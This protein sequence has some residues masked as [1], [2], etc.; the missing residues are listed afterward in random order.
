MTSS[1]DK[2]VAGR[3]YIPASRP[4]GLAHDRR[5]WLKAAEGLACVGA[6]KHF[7]IIRF[8]QDSAPAVLL[9]YHSE[10]FDTPL[11]ES[12]QG[13]LVDLG[14]GRTERRPRERKQ[15]RFIRQMGGC[16]RP[17]VEQAISR[18]CATLPCRSGRVRRR[19]ALQVVSG[20]P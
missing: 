18:G 12:L 7:N 6:G 8:E 11:P 9:G 10:Y 5:T 15:I 1:P 2:T 19:V 17:A 16:P 13:R 3:K 20:T 14:P 4:E